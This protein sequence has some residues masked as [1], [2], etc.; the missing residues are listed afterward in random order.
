MCMDTGPSARVWQ[1]LWTALLEKTGSPSL[2]SHQLPVAAQIRDFM[3]PSPTHAGILTSLIVCRSVILCKQPHLLRFHAH[4]EP[5]M[6]GEYCAADDIHYLWL[7]VFRPS[8]P[9][10]SLGLGVV[11]HGMFHVELSTPQSLMIFIL[12]SVGLLINHHLLQKLGFF[13]D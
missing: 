3:N 12:A 5:A 11:G 6:L 10:W 8:L 2:S 7:L 4:N 9:Q 1:P 13:C